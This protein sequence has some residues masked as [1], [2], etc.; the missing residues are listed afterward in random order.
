MNI[1]RKVLAATIAIIFLSAA[2]ATESAAATCRSILARTTLIAHSGLLVETMP[3][4]ANPDAGNPPGTRAPTE[5]WKD[6][7]ANPNAGN[8]PGAGTEA[9]SEFQ[10]V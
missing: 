3:F 5:T 1:R 10:S 2:A 4:R 7:K 6:P 9:S 8:P